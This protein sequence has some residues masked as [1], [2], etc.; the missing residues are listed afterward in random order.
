MGT[1]EDPV[2]LITGRFSAISTSDV[3]RGSKPTKRVGKSGSLDV[4]KH[5][6]PMKSLKMAQRQNSHTDMRHT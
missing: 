4:M 5:I 2:P 6:D 3:L 1:M